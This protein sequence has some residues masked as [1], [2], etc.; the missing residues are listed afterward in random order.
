MRMKI[1]RAIRALLRPFKPYVIEA[2]CLGLALARGLYLVAT[3]GKTEDRYC[4]TVFYVPRKEYDHF[5]ARTSSER[6]Q[7][8][9]YSAIRA[10]FAKH[11]LSTLLDIGCGTGF[12]LM[13]YFSSYA[14]LGLERPP[15]LEALKSSYPDKRWE[16]SDFERIPEETFDMVISVDVIEHLSDP[17]ELME[18][19][20]KIDS[21]F[22]A[23]S[24]PDRG[25]LSRQSKIGPPRNRYHMREWSQEEFVKYVSRYFQV[26]ESEVVSNHEHYVICTRRDRRA[27]V[28]RNAR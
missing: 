12:K 26:I 22:I 10:F 1:P 7:D 28:R 19:V 4:I 11:Q 24:T 3:T 6:P 13:K 8:R 17:D 23:L 21:K 9:V 15:V 14:T 27:A 5:D 20:S 18:F 2:Q 25:N 16:M